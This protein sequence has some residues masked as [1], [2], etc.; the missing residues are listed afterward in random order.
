MSI[1]KI[2]KYPK[3]IFIDK[4]IVNFEIISLSK[5]I[6]KPISIEIKRTLKKFSFLWN[7]LVNPTITNAK[8]TIKKG[9]KI[10]DK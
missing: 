5:K 9:F 3:K 4:L 6:I 1:K 8:T 2:N 10:S 7:L